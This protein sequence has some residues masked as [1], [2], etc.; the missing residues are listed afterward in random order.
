MSIADVTLL[1]GGG[2]WPYWSVR[3]TSSRFLRRAF[4]S[5]CE[6]TRRPSVK[7]NGSGSSALA[8]LAVLVAAADQMTIKAIAIKVGMIMIKV[9]S[10]F[11]S[12]G[13]WDAFLALKKKLAPDI[14]KQKKKAG[15]DMGE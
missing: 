12:Q 6:A 14:A 10:A 4:Q 13:T 3:I 11:L 5:S 8:A 7:R 2:R 1:G 15:A 9:G